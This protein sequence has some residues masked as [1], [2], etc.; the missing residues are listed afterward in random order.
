MSYRNIL[1]FSA[2]FKICIDP[3]QVKTFLETVEY[4]RN[5]KDDHLCD[6]TLSF[7]LT[8]LW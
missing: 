1:L 7:S 6:I 3:L 2:G 8:L 5:H 4:L